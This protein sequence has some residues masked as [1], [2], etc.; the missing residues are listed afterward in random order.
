MYN[1]EIVR[2]IMGT[3]GEDRPAVPLKADLLASV[4]M[5]HS[6]ICQTSCAD[7][8]GDMPEAM[9]AHRTA[10]GRNAELKAALGMPQLRYPTMHHGA[11]KMFAAGEL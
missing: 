1:P 7:A 11:S 6:D 2:R 4:I 5:G 8:T 10:K 9:R 3:G